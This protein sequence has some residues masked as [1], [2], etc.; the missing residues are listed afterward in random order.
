[1]RLKKYTGHYLTAELPKRREKFS[2]V[3]LRGEH[4][5]QTVLFQ[6]QVVSQPATTILSLPGFRRKLTAWQKRPLRP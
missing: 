3:N 2:I 6:S 4:G 1:M 5:R